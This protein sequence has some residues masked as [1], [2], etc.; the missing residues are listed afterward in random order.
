M[1]IEPGEEAVRVEV[2]VGQQMAKGGKLFF[3]CFFSFISFLFSFLFSIFRRGLGAIN[4][5]NG[6]GYV[7]V[8][9]FCNTTIGD[10]SAVLKH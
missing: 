2:V 1:V 3:F 8:D 5:S 7:A 6:G 10:G 9:C 4:D